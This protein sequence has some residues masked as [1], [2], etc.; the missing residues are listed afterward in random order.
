[1]FMILKMSLQYYTLNSVGQLKNVEMIK[2]TND[3]KNFGR[4]NP[5]NFFSKLT[6]ECS[7]LLQKQVHSKT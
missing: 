6:F 5:C 2:I 4:N 3:I 7:F 1:M